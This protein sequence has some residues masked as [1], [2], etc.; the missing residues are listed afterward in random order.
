MEGLIN[1]G[2][3]LW[4]SGVGGEHIPVAGNQGSCADFLAEA[5]SLADGKISDNSEFLAIVIPLV[6]RQDGMGGVVAPGGLNHQR[7]ERRVTGMVD[8]VA[9]DGD[10]IADKLVLTA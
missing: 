10:T 5:K 8:A 4:G 9:S 6:H 1:C 3:L 7:M 2:N